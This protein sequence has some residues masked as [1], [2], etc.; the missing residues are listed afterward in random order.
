M[1]AAVRRTEFRGFTSTPHHRGTSRLWTRVSP[2]QLVG[3]AAKVG[4][5]SKSVVDPGLQR[6]N[7]FTELNGRDLL[8]VTARDQFRAARSVSISLGKTE[9]PRPG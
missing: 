9:F 4:L 6:S 7:Q 1:T 3:M 5:N 8:L 2:A